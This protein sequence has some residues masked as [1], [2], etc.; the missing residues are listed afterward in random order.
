ML[1]VKSIV[2]VIF[3]AI[4]CAA[5]PAVAPSNA[6]REE[7]AMCPACP[8][9]DVLQVFSKSV[10]RPGLVPAQ[11]EAFLCPRKRD[12]A[13]AC[14]DERLHGW[15]SGHVEYPFAVDPSGAVLPPASYLEGAA[16]EIENGER[17]E[18]SDELA[19]CVEHVVE[20]WEF[21]RS[22][23]PTWMVI[24]FDFNRQSPGDQAPP[25]RSQGVRASHQLGRLV[26]TPSR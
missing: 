25:G 12:V 4:G 6:A 24:Q 2:V 8:S 17:R 9:S 7:Q 23:F 19:Q 18:S 10:R 1:G 3:C 22:N 13:K 26:R 16:A 11:I 20:S 21:P 5:R 15:E 14:W